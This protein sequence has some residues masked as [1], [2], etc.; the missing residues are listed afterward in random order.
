MKV[1]LVKPGSDQDALNRKTSEDDNEAELSALLAICAARD[2]G[3]IKRR[4][5]L[6]MDKKMNQAI[7]SMLLARGNYA[8]A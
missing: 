5:I 8:T 6:K 3:L 2:L 1:I 7:N 4:N